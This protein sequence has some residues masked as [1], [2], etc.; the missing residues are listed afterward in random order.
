MNSIKPINKIELPVLKAWKR[1]F[2]LLE[3]ICCHEYDREG[4]QD[5]VLRLYGGEKS[6][7]SVFRGMA[8]PTLRNLGLIVGFGDVIHASA[9]GL[10]TVLAYERSKTDG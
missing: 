3:C 7:K 2:E 6:S 5:A 4:F 8:I 9:N 10:L 1:I